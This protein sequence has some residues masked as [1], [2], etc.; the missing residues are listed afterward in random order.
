MLF[1][2]SGVYASPNKAKKQE[3]TAQQEPEYSVRKTLKELRSCIH[4]S[5]IWTYVHTYQQI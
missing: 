5:C 3:A 2:Y 4:V 1:C